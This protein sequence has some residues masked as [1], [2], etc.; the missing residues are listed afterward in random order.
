MIQGRPRRRI[1]SVAAAF[2]LALV[3]GVSAAYAWAPTLTVN[4]KLTRTWSWDIEKSADKGTVTL[5]PGE[6][7]TVNYSVSVKTT[8]FTDSDWTVFG[9]ATFPTEPTVLMT[10]IRAWTINLATGQPDIHGTATCP[11]G[12][13][14]LLTSPLTCNYSVAV[15]NANSGKVHVEGT[16]LENG[17]L[18]GAYDDQ[19]FSFASATVNEID[20]CV[21]V[22]DTFAGALGTVCAGD[23]PKTFTYSRTIGPFTSDQCGEHVVT[24]TASLVTNDRG[25]QD[26]ASADVKVTVVCEP[27]KGCT[28]TI[29]YWKTHAGFGPQADVVTP[30]LPVRLGTSGGAK[31]INVTTAAQ[32]VS[33]LSITTASNGIDKLYAQLLGAKLSGA[34]G[35]DLSA[36]ASTIAAADAFLATNNSASWATLT[37]AQKNM[38]LGWMETLDNYNN[39]LIGPVHCD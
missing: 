27:P 37:K 22:T 14:Q 10:D 32:A 34:S 7:A 15:P 19:P 16:G 24:N 28:H 1:L 3:V 12:L 36:V 18:V 13:P 4:T 31:S 11:P 20:E 2:A 26:S 39:G 21:N 6:T 17:N 23:A 33:L 8:G 25:L 35:A 5:A 9:T 29:G 38:V 30:L